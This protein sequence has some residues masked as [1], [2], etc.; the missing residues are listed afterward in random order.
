MQKDFFMKIFTYRYQG[1]ARLIGMTAASLFFGLAA[2]AQ[3][4]PGED[5]V[6]LTSRISVQML[7]IG[8]ANASAPLNAQ[9]GMPAWMQAKVARFEAK[10]NSDQGSDILTD[11]NVTRSASSDGLKKTCIQEI[12]S[13]TAQ[14]PGK[15]GL[16]NTQQIVV[17][18]GDLVNICK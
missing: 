5:P 13:N 10:A 15:F 3:N 16:A 7:P 11:S 9:N 1:L 8:G 2:Q 17:L 12:G 6:V 4:A 14:G 18:K